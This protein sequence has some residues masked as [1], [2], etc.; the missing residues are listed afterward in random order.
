MIQ[1]SKGDEQWIHFKIHLYTYVL[2]S[3]V[4]CA[5]ARDMPTLSKIPVLDWENALH[6]KVLPFK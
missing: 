1:K 6:R 2:V 5:E 3:S 4:W